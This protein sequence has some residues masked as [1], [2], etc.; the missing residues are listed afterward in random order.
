MCS[1]V[2]LQAGGGGG[3][4]RGGG[5]HSVVENM[6]ELWSADQYS[7]EYDLTSF[8]RSLATT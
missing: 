8:M 2:G 6:P 4:K 1:L 5:M 3:V 7:S